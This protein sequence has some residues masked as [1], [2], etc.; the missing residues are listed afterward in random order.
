M[1]WRDVYKNQLK[2]AGD[3]LKSIDYKSV[4]DFIDLINLTKGVV[5]FTGIGKN[6]HVAAKT[7]STYGSM[8][9]KSFFIDPVDALHGGMNIVQKDDIL[10]A[11]SKSGCTGELYHFLK[12]LKIKNKDVKIIL[13][14]S[15]PNSTCKEFS[16]LD[17]QID[18]ENE[19]DKFN[20]VPIASISIFTIFLQ[21]IAVDMSYRNNLTETD[22]LSNHPGGSIGKLNK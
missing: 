12:Q 6:G 11:V 13:I 10:V 1:K 8:N 14:H 5:F 21:S 18:I 20:I 9:I 19:N 16:S 2:Q 17:I 22:F 4:E 7:A 3:S 15:N